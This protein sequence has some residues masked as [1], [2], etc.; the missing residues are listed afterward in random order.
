MVD[1]RRAEWRD[2]VHF[3][4]V[5]AHVMRRI[6]VDHA[7]RHRTGKRGGEWTKV[8]FH[9]ALAPSASRTLDVIALDDALQDLAKLN[10]QH[11]HIVELRFF[12][13][14]NTE[15]VAEVLDISPRSVQRE[16]RMARAWLRRHIFADRA[17]S[18]RS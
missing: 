18:T 14:M 15:E 12:G 16:W 10:P 11:S 4:T 2:R 9:E 1:Q 3:L 6:L 17:E 7:R 8:E 13:G 5:A